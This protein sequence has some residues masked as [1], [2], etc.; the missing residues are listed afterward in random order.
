MRI[1]YQVNPERHFT[2]SKALKSSSKIIQNTVRILFWGFSRSLSL[3]WVG[4][5]ALSLP[6]R[7]QSYK[8]I[9]V[10]RL[11]TAAQVECLTASSRCSAEQLI[12]MRIRATFIILTTYRATARTTTASASACPCWRML[13]NHAG[14]ELGVR[15]QEHTAHSTPHATYRTRAP[16]VC[17]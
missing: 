10:V 9:I 14:S 2:V 13:C 8:S 7:Y 1:L 4:Y 17:N 5:V 3:Y 15:Y 11:L 6:P 12:S 16:V